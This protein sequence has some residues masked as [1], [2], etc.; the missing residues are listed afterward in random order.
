MI[1]KGEKGFTLIELLIVVAIL[2]VLA[3]VVIP[4]VGRFIGTGEDEAKNTE[5]TTIQN[6]VQALMVA[7]GVGSFDVGTF[8]DSSDNATN[9]MSEFPVT[10]AN[11]TLVLWGSDNGN[12][13]ATQLTTYEYWVDEDGTVYQS[14]EKAE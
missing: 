12:L 9:D 13:V 3:A 4:N 6:A 10:T 11:S 7:E 2:G 8:F 1:R 14:T 5:F